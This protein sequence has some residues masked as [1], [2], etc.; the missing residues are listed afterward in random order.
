MEFI[1]IYFLN[2]QMLLINIQSFYLIFYHFFYKFQINI[3]SNE[4]YQLS[5]E[6]IDEFKG[7][8]SEFDLYLIQ[9][10]ESLHR[11]QPRS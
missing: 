9:Q 11:G 8:I 1:F 2:Y 3:E 10:W 5:V 6:N 4:N 7:N